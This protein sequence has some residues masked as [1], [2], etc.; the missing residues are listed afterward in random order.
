MNAT[1]IVISDDLRVRL[2]SVSRHNPAFN[3]APD[4]DIPEEPESQSLLL[5]HKA[6]S[7][8][9]S[10][11]VG[12]GAFM[13]EVEEAPNQTEVTGARR[14]SSA[15]DHNDARAKMMLMKERRMVMCVVL[16]LV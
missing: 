2:Q 11:A 3:A 9:A 15:L 14:R 6:H 13:E 16:P 4:D 10:D 7:V 5:S 8:S 12:L 1:Q